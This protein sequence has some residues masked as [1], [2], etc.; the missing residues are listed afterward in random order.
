MRLKIVLDIANGLEYLHTQNP[1]IAHIDLK[2]AN[3]EP[4]FSPRGG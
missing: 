2:G 1:P 4:S 3:G